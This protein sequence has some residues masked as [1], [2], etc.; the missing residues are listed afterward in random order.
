VQI[1]EQIAAKRQSPAPATRV[2]EGEIELYAEGQI[3]QQISALNMTEALR[4]FLGLRHP[5]AISRLLPF[6]GFGE[7]QKVVFRRIRDRL[8]ATLGLPVLVTP[9]LLIFIPSGKSTRAAPRKDSSCC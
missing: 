4:T 6:V 7:A 9:V 1:L 8:K 5:Q 3:R 2:R